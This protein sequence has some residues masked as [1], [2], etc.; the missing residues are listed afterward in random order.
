MDESQP[1]KANEDLDSKPMFFFFRR[2]QNTQ[3]QQPNDAS[4]AQTDTNHVQPAAQLAA[5]TKGN[6]NWP[7]CA[8]GTKNK[9]HSSGCETIDDTLAGN[10][11]QTVAFNQRT[12][13]KPGQQEKSRCQ[14]KSK[15]TMR[16]R[17]LH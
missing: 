16:T 4:V 17:Q 12:A 10:A 9:F 2:T 7:T 13:A 1:N 6:Q 15:A 14:T 5:F 8:L 3:P 11:T